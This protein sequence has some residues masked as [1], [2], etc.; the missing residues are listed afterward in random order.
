MKREQLVELARKLGVSEKY[1]TAS[2]KRLIWAIQ[3]A[4]GQNPCYLGDER[5]SC[6]AKCQWDKSCKKLTAAWL[7]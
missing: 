6:N 2:S 1:Y 5:Y 7:R 3:E 4:Q